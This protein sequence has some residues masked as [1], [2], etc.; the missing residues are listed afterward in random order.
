MGKVLEKPGTALHTLT[1]Q[2]LWPTMGTCSISH[3]FGRDRQK[4]AAEY[5]SCPVDIK[6]SDTLPHLRR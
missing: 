3:Y 5:G 2:F 1:S 6:F 4:E